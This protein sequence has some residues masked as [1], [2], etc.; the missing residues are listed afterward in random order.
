MITMR[1]VSSELMTSFSCLSLVDIKVNI[2]DSELRERDIGETRFVFYHFSTKT[3]DDAGSWLAEHFTK[4][5]WREE[6]AATEVE[7]TVCFDSQHRKRHTTFKR[8]AKI[9]EETR[10][11]WHTE[12]GSASDRYTE[13]FTRNGSPSGRVDFHLDWRQ[14]SVQPPDKEVAST[15]LQISEDKQSLFR[16]WHHPALATLSNQNPPLFF[17]EIQNVVVPLPGGKE[18]ELAVETPA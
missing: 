3:I 13:P 11:R 8:R 6:R 4:S 15:Y 1:N 18:A 10:R 17:L 7:A 16:A 14:W 2:T 9:E 5:V 12:Q